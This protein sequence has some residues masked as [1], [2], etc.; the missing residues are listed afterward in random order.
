[1]THSTG[2]LSLFAIEAAATF[3][4]IILAFL[5]PRLGNRCFRRVE[6]AVARVARKRKLAVLTV[7]GSA[8]LIRLAILPVSPVPHPFIHDE[9]SFLLAGDTFASGRLTNPTHPMWEH[10][11]SFHIDQQPTYMSMYPPAQGLVL[12]AG[13]RLL[14][15]PWFGVWLSCGVMCAAI[16][17][18]LQG[19]F[20]PGWAFFGGILCVIRIALFSEWIDSYNGG[21]VAAIGGALV[22]GTFPRLLKPRPLEQRKV[23]LGLTLAAGFAILANSRPWEGVWL[24]IGVIAAFSY[25]M[26]RTRVLLPWRQFWMPVSAMLLIVCAAMGYYNWR[27]FGSPLTLP[28]Q[29]NRAA[30]AVSPVFIWQKLTPEPVYRHKEMRTFYVSREADVFLRSKTAAGF[31]KELF[32]KIGIGG[33]FFFAAALLPPLAML[34]MIVFDRRMRPLLIIGSIF[35][36]GVA[37][38]AFFFPRYAAP[39]ACLIYAVLIQCLRH[40]RLVSVSGEPVGRFLVRVIPVVCVLAAGLRVAHEPL[41]IQVERFPTLWYG[42]GPLGIPRAK[43]A[44]DLQAQPGKQLLIVRYAPNHDSFDEWVYNDADIDGAKVVWAREMSPERNRKLIDYFHDRR[45]WLVEPDQDPPVI[46]PYP[47]SNQVLAHE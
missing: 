34:P 33:A 7:G 44:S 41:H 19:W 12:A 9:F 35:F 40:L 16:C 43:V 5:A 8:L 39:V 26:R 42:P 15:D 24:G 13:K 6:T 25:E 2:G 27:V 28:Y 10:F 36:L 46:V 23:L 18:M 17:W 1:M 37:L 30:Y 31:V 20:S 32:R 4:A 38:N 47:E 3:L 14:G 45:V 22:V 11:E 29:V 21:A